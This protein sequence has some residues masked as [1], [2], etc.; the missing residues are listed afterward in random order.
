MSRVNKL[1][2][3]THMCNGESNNSIPV[4]CT[5]I[6]GTKMKFTLE[7]AMKTWARE[8]RY[9]STLSLTSMLD[10]VGGQYH[11]SATLPL[12]TRPGTHLK[13]AGWAPGP[14]WMGGE[15]LAQ[16]RM[17]NHYLQQYSH[18]SNRKKLQV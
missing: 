14:V 17:Y 11:T 8:Y 3:S 12:D 4:K 2:G 18:S 1:K 9:I 7:E 10:G 5:T 16:A 15:N 6:K 13:E